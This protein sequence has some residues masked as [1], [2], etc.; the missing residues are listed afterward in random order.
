M[1]SLPSID[2]LRE[3]D[4]P[5]MLAVFPHPKKVFTHRLCITEA[6]Q[7]DESIAALVQEAHDEIGPGTRSR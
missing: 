2:L 7:L 6:A 3:A 1:P 5:F 4:H